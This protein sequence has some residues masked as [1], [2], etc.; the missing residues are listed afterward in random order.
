MLVFLSLRIT[1]W[2]SKLGEY[3]KRW[4]HDL[5]QGVWRYTGSQNWEHN[6]FCKLEGTQI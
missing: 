4:A 5:V 1:T 2:F 3:S 6:S